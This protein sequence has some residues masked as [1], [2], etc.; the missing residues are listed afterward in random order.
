MAQPIKRTDITDKIKEAVVEPAQFTDPET[1]SV[2]DYLQ[3]TLTFEKPDGE[4]YSVV[5]SIKRDSYHIITLCKDQ[6]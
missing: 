2:I 5:K 3:L 1:K 6:V 4:E